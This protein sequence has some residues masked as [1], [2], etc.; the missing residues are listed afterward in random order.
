MRLEGWKPG[1]HQEAN[2]TE[3]MTHEQQFPPLPRV[4]VGVREK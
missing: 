2:E 4:S 3:G 1:F